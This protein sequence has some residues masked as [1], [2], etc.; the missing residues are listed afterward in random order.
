M[1]TKGIKYITNIVSSI[2]PII[3][4]YLLLVYILGDWDI[5]QYSKTGN[6]LLSVSL[7][8]MHYWAYHVLR[9]FIEY[10]I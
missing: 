1:E 8:Q 4:L 3:V 2:F 5:T 9:L 6:S 10:L 7:L